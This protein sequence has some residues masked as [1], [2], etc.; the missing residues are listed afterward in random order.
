ME[1]WIAGGKSGGVRK[2]GGGGLVED[3]KLGGTRTC[4]FYALS[5]GFEV[6]WKLRGAMFHQLRKATKLSIH[7]WVLTAPC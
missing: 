2:G 1:R 5:G 3:G 7:K 6:G 4:D